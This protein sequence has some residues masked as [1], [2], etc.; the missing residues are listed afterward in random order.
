[1]RGS[2][3]PGRQGGAW[4]MMF[5]GRLGFGLYRHFAFALGGSGAARAGTRG[6]PPN[7]MFSISAPR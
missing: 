2:S 7:R 5:V 3:M 6:S 4:L 1:M